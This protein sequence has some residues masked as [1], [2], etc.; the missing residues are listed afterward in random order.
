MKKNLLAGTNLCPKRRLKKVAVLFLAAL[1]GMVFALSVFLPLEPKLMAMY[2]HQRQTT[3]ECFA[4]LEGREVAVEADYMKKA[5]VTW[6]V[7]QE[8]K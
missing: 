4:I 1:I 3:H 5:I 7:Y 6:E 8:V 2:L